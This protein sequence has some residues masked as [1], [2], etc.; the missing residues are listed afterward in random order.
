MNQL[1]QD[2]AP[3]V[4]CQMLP[5]ITCLVLPAS[6]REGGEVRFR[7]YSLCSNLTLISLPLH[8]PLVFLQGLAKGGI[9]NMYTDKEIGI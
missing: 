1:I 4:A 7:G 2:H 5:P 6:E 8:P 3:E 9:V